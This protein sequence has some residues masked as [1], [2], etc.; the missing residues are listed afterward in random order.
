MSIR[1]AVGFTFACFAVSGC[2]GM[3]IGTGSTGSGS[4][5][6]PSADAATGTAPDG[7]GATGV[8]CITEST[9]GATICSGTTQC[10]SV[11]VD[12]DIYPD[13]GFRVVGANATL[14]L[15]CACDEGMLCPLGIASSCA[16]AATMLQNQTEATV[17]QQ[18]SE[19]RCSRGT[20][21][22]SSSGGSNSNCNATCESECA[23]APACIAAC[24]C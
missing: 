6:G 22:A 21:T 24:G 23:G 16:E 7:G 1:A 2:V 15:E 9:T 19:G 17:C 10:P 3:N 11:T 12:H 13:C 5:S 14:D 8:D 20:G 4:S 18:I